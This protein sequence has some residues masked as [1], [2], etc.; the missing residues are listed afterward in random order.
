MLMELTPAYSR[1]YRSRAEAL[2]DFNSDKDFVAAAYGSYT[3][4]SDLRSAGITE[5][6]LRYWNN[7]RI[8]VVKM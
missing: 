1:D 6:L 4:K 8:A 3:N 7:T 2:A 5:V